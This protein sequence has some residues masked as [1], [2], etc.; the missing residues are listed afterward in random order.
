MPGNL[1]VA[2]AVANQPGAVVPDRY[3]TRS[4]MSSGIPLTWNPSRPDFD[5]HLARLIL[6]EVLAVR[7]YYEGDF[8]PLTRITADEDCWLAYQYDRPDLGEGIIMAFRRPMA[9]ERSIVVRLEGLDPGTAYELKNLDSGE[10]RT[11]TG[12]ELCAQLRLTSESKPQ[13]LLFTYK[14]RNTGIRSPGHG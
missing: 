4:A 2:I 11:A 14:R 12:K 6:E 10:R 1:A 13:S 9:L 3:M 5:D 8:Y 7:H